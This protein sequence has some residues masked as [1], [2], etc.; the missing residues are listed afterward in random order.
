MGDTHKV[1]RRVKGGEKEVTQPHLVNSYNKGMG[2][3][4]IMDRLS[5]SYLPMIGGKKWYWQLFLNMIN[6]A[7]IA[8]WMIHCKVHPE[9]LS[10]LEFWRHVTLCLLKGDAVHIRAPGGGE[11]LPEDVTYDGMNHILGSTYY[12]RSMQ[13]LS[14]I[15]KTLTLILKMWKK[16]NVRLHAERGKECFEMHHSKQTK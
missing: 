4:D 13:I 8:A 10:H 5:E 11:T 1:K 14:L 2:G 9:K 15:L 16:C 3:V 7:M 6:V 12:T